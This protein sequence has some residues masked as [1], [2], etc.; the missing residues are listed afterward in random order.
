LEVDLDSAAAPVAS[1]VWLAYS[2][3]GVAWTPVPLTAVSTV[4]LY[5]QPT[6]AADSD[7]VVVALRATAGSAWQARAA[8][9]ARRFAGR[10]VRLAR[11]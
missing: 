8:S 6:I 3:D 4:I 5:E 11:P 2:A 10:V 1:R 7:K 9:F